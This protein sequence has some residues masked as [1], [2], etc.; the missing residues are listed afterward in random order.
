MSD[1]LRSQTASSQESS[2][3]GEGHS[4]RGGVDDR[5]LHFISLDEFFQLTSGL[6]SWCPLSGANFGLV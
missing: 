6:W 5:A 1:K 4:S 2:V 3:D